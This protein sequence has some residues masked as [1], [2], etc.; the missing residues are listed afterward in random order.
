MLEIDSIITILSFVINEERQLEY[1]YDVMDDMTDDVQIHTLKNLIRDR[2]GAIQDSKALRVID[3][4]QR[5][6]DVPDDYSCPICWEK[7]EDHVRLSCDHVVCGP[8]MVKIM[9]TEPETRV[10]PMCRR[11]I[12]SD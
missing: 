12:L 4:L 8:C 5:A 2:L 1:V 3:S 6:N 10:C 9:G 11:R 7:S